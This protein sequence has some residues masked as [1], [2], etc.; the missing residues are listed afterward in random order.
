M[1][2]PFVLRAYFQVQLFTSGVT[3][4][5]RRLEAQRN[6]L[7]AKGKLNTLI[8]PGGG[9]IGS[10]LQIAYKWWGGRK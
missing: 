8:E 10:T 2:N 1:P 5:L 7:N 3:Q 9:G 4:N 6:E